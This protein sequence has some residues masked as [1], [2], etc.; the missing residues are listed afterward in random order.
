LSLLSPCNTNASIVLIQTGSINTSSGVFTD[1]LKFYTTGSNGKSHYTLS[2]DN[3][4]NIEDIFST[5]PYQPTKDFYLINNYTDL[6]SFSGSGYIS[7]SMSS[8]IAPFINHL[9][10]TYNHATTPWV[11]NLQG[12]QLFK[13]HHIGDGNYTNKNIKIAI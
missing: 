9:S 11:S 12:D 4:Y 3:V 1:T 13:I 2:A 5:E 10:Q 6:T 7:V 8:L